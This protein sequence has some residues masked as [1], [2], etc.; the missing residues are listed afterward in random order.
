MKCAGCNREMKNGDLCIRGTVSELTGQPENAA[1][2]SIMATIWG[3]GGDIVLC[4]S[5]TMPGGKFEVE[6]YHEESQS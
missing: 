5:C 1:V 2:D 4:Q 3:G 6:V